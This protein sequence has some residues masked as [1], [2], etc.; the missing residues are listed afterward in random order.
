LGE[1]KKSSSRERDPATG[2]LLNWKGVLLSSFVEKV[3]DHLSPENRSHIDLII[4]KGSA[5]TQALIPR[6]MITKYPL[7][8]ALSSDKNERKQGTGTGVS[9]VPP[10]SSKPKIMDEGLPIENYFLFN[11]NRIELTSYKDRFSSLFLKR[12]TDPSAM[13]GEKLFVQNCVSCH[14][15]GD[16]RVYKLGTL[17]ADTDGVH[18][19]MKGALKLSEKDKKSLLSYLS[20]FKGEN[21]DATTVGG[22]TVKPEGRNQVGAGVVAGK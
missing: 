1:F 14:A 7:I 9:V 10:W 5:G 19:A 6:A 17:G 22:A 20:A 16:A 11:V 4:L 8:L 21:P 13:R 18:P 15:E 2:K 12:R 3:L